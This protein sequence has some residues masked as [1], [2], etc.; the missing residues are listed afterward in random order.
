MKLPV[1]LAALTLCALA[2]P[3]LA[4]PAAAQAE[5][6]AS[7]EA[8]ARPSKASIAVMPFTYSREVLDV[9]DDHV[10]VAVR[11]FETSAFTNKFITALVNTRKFD[12]VERSRIDEL[13]DEMEMSESGLMDTARAVRAGQVVGADYI[14][15]GEITVFAITVEWSRIPN[16]TRHSRKVTAQIVVDMR[17]VDTRTSRIVA[18]ER[19]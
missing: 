17:I 19:G 11:E 13:M 2:L 14:L 3:A 9:D 12:V 7:D 6:P 1:R 15:M 4:G 5:D 8:P 10:R 18:A 16:T